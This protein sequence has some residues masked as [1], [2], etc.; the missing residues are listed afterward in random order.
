MKVRRFRLRSRNKC[1]RIERLPRTKK[2]GK[3]TLPYIGISE[4]R[5]EE[6]AE[7]AELIAHEHSPNGSVDPEWIA[8]SKGITISYGHYRD[9]FDGLLEHCSDRFHI[10]CNLDRLTRKE[11]PRTKFTLAH[12]LGHFFIVEHSLALRS[13]RSPGHGSFTEYE[14][15]NP[16]EQEA[17]HF[18]S[19]LLMP[20]ERFLRLASKEPAGIPGIITLARHFGTSLTSTAIRYASLEVKP[21]FVVKWSAD[22]F[23][24]KWLSTRTR[25]ANYRKTIEELSNIVPGSATARAL[26]GE[27]IPETGFFQTGT[28]ASAWFPFVSQGARRNIILIEQAIALGRFGVLTFIYPERGDFLAESI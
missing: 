24:W 15:K 27:N 16:V 12:E 23:N 8:K 19:S 3:A 20:K 7:L 6:I 11:N 14:S 9:S 13:G 21:C 10:Y 28:T 1:G 22:G 25:L 17:D 5:K 4:A 2:I 26:A 18:A